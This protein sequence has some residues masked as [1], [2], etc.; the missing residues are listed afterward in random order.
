METNNYL[1]L[2]D[3][4]IEKIFVDR[5]I[6]S[7]NFNSY[8]ELFIYNNEVYKI[9]LKN[10][11]LS[12][13]NIDTI[14]KLFEYKNEVSQIKEI[15]LPRKLL[16][17]NNQ[18]VGYKMPLIKGTLLIDV[19]QYE[20]L[21]KTTIKSYFIQL[22]RIINQTR[23]FSFQFS[24]NDL[25]EKNIIIDKDGNLNIIDSDGFVINNNMYREQNT[26]VYGKYLNNS[27]TTKEPN[28]I[29]YICLLCMILNYLLKD[30]KDYNF[31]PLSLFES[32][33]IHNITIK[34]IFRKV[35]FKSF[36]LT[37]QDIENLFSLDLNFSKHKVKFLARFKCKNQL[38][39]IER[40]RLK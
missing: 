30:V 4:D 19:L 8:S 12:K 33:K 11:E 26:I 25:H 27:I 22:L 13:Q 36:I 21:D 9:Y 2:S 17:Y 24:F 32:S 38:K 37:E 1:E 29:D 5:I 31:N 18:I 6:Q 39:K 23:S 7:E 34:E 40:L 15:V 35:R 20:K 28:S 14:I 10:P 16:V 3:K